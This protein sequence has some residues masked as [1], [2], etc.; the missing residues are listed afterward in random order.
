MSKYTKEELDEIIDKEVEIV[1]GE[2]NNDE[3]T[4][5]FKGK[6]ISY[7]TAA[8]DPNLPADFYFHTEHG[9]IKKINFSSLKNIRIL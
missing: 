7:N 5:S 8:E 2:I 9:A 3:D 4:F 1:L 6:I